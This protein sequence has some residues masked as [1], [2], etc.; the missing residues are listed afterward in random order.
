MFVAE[1]RNANAI[2]YAKK[3]TNALLYHFFPVTTA[4]VL[5]LGI[6]LLG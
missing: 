2:A 4:S 5:V 6:T 1:K 3:K